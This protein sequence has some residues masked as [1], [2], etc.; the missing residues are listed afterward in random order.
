MCIAAR[1]A[2]ELSDLKL[3]REFET[4]RL[5]HEEK[6]LHH[7]DEQE[8]LDKSDKRLFISEKSIKSPLHKKPDVFSVSN[9]ILDD[10]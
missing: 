3:A 2:K 4:A 8:V 7:V 6:M 5:N 10:F 1:A 9:E